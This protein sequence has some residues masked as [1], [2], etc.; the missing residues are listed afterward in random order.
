MGFLALEVIAT[1]EIPIKTWT[2]YLRSS[3]SAEWSKI[4][5]AVICVLDKTLIYIEHSHPLLHTI[6]K[7]SQSRKKSSSG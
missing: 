5:F 3:L 1:L 6:Q 7:Y 4:I 2:V